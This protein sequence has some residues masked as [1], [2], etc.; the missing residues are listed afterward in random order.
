M[1]VFQH[2]LWGFSLT[3]PDTWVHRTNADLDGFA[4]TAAA[5]D[6]AG[7]IDHQAAHILVRG[8][9][10][11]RNEPIAPL[12]NQHITKL[13]I[14]LGAK[15]LGSSPFSIG[16]ANGFEVEI[17]LPKRQNRRLWAGILVRDKVILHFMVS[18]PRDERAVFEPQA[19]KIIASLRFLKQIEGLD[20]NTEG[21]PLPPNYI[22]V[23]PT[24]HIHDLSGRDNWK[25]YEGNS[26]LNALQNFYYRELPHHGW[27][28]REF[29]P[30][31][32]QVEISFARLRIHK[33]DLSATLGILPTVEKNPYGKIV[34]KYEQKN[35]KGLIR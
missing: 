31:P 32:N 17:Q 8:E 26:A 35:L 7:A 5:F 14:M 24:T 11:G 2:L 19:T 27:E 18:H 6:Q 30:Y 21:L 1:A 4:E 34:V 15:K 29:I 12:W 33:D 13:S 28:I 3:Y 22:P 9:F 23:D 20:A 25:A 10:N 16:G